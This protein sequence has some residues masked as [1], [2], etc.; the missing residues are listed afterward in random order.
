MTQVNLFAKQKQTQ[1]YRKQTYGY[2]SEN[3][4]GRDKLEICE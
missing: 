1:K 4:R 2:Q 3:I